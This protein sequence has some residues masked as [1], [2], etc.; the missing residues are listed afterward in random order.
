MEIILNIHNPDE[1]LDGTE[2]W[3]TD[4]RHLN[5]REKAIRNIKPTRG[6]LKFERQKIRFYPF[7]KNN[8]LKLKEIKTFDNTNYP[9]EIKCFTT[10]EECKSEYKKQFVVI[11]KEFKKY[12]Q[13]VIQQCND[14]TQKFSTL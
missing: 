1:K 9:T 8:E 3:I 12:E 11:L 13:T 6:V 14:L 4:Y 5:I 7:K 2:C 10:E